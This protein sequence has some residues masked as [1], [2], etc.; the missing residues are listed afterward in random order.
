VLTF[1]KLIFKIQYA[2][3]SQSICLPD[4]QQFYENSAGFLAFSGQDVNILGWLRAP[5][6]INHEITILSV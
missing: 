4:P 5:L 1:A 6:P 2:Y 3:Y